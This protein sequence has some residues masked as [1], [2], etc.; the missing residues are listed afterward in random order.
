MPTV[1]LSP[2]TSVIA[3][4]GIRYFNAVVERNQRP[5][6]ARVL[7]SVSYNGSPV[8]VESYACMYGRSRINVGHDNSL[9]TEISISSTGRLSVG[10][11]VVPG[12][13]ITIMVVVLSGASDVIANSCEATVT[14]V[15]DNY[16]VNPTGIT[17][18]PFELLM[19]RGDSRLFVANVSPAGAAHNAIVWTLDP[20]IDGVSISGIGRLTVADNA[21]LGAQTR[22][23][24]SIPGTSLAAESLITIVGDNNGAGQYMLRVMPGYLDPTRVERGGTRQFAAAVERDGEAVPATIAWSIVPPVEGA[25]ID[26]T[27]G[28]LTVE[29]GVSAGTL[30]TVRATAMVGGNHLQ[31]TARATVVAVGETISP[32]SIA[33]IPSSTYVMQGGF[34][35]FGATVLPANA[36]HDAVAWAIYSSAR[37]D[38]RISDT[39]ILMVDDNAAPGQVIIRAAIPG[40]ALAAVAVVTIVAPS[41]PDPRLE[42]RVVPDSTNVEQG[43]TRL[44]AA[45]VEKDDYPVDDSPQIWWNIVYPVSGVSI[46][47][48]DPAT[49]QLTIGQH[50]PIGT[51]I[52]VRATAFFDGSL[53]HGMAVAT[54]VETVVD[55]ERIYVYP[56]DPYAIQGEFRQFAATV[57]PA[58]AHHDAV[59][60]SIVYPNLVPAGIQMNSTGA[61]VIASNV[62]QTTIVVRASIPNTTPEVYREISVDIVDGADHRISLTR[63]GGFAVPSPLTFDPKVVGYA[64]VEP[65]QIIV[66]NIGTRPTGQLVITVTGPQALAAE[67]GIFRRRATPLAAE[68]AVSFTVTLP[69]GGINLAV[70]ESG[71]FEVGP[72]HGLPSGTHTGTVTVAGPAGSPIEAHTFN[73]SFHVSPYPPLDPPTNVTVDND[74][75]YVSWTGSAGSAGYRVYA[76]GVEVYMVTTGTTFNLAAHNAPR[77]P[78]GTNQIAVIAIGVPGTSADSGLS[79]PPVVFYQRLLAPVIYIDID[80]VVSWNAVPGAASY[81]VYRADTPNPVLVG[82]AT[83]AVPEPTAAQIRRLAPR[84]GVVAASAATTTTVTFDLLCDVRTP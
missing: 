75:G 74:T 73:V 76:G 44:F 36:D 55:P 8:S 28:E 51:Q 78:V 59:V 45:S 14:V 50:V 1:T 62:P 56:L 48:V 40:T 67:Q 15:S 49:G 23:R 18:T 37:T 33:V 27:M 64:P 7:W 16:I 30:I 9:D 39:G 79:S 3:P 46:N 53:L 19:P 71:T 12:T 22:L 68:E 35:P 63:P 72:N 11:D 82:T 54:V 70:G 2:N 4:G 61:L 29:Y 42:V 34:R 5:A 60:W 69:S 32:S 31:G 84:S 26:P 13:V 47:P 43:M 65:L 21:E 24:A 38:V 81:R 10:S 41:V 83:A 57:Y 25:S 20:Q 77:L 66:T 52:T 17:V 80:G 6:L 58:Y